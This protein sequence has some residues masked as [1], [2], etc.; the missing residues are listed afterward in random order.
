[1]K[2]VLFSTRP[3]AHMEKMLQFAIALLLSD[4]SSFT[5]T[6]LFDNYIYNCQSNLLEL[7]AVN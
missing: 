3:D 1:M 5:E 7:Y 6:K 2:F 4:R